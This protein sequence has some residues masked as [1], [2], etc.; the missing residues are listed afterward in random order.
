MDI[1]EIAKKKVLDKTKENLVFPM[2]EQQLTQEQKQ[3]IVSHAK[4]IGC[5]YRDVLDLVLSNEVGY[6]S[7]VA[8]NTSRQDYYEDALVNYI[9]SLNIVANVRKLPKSGFG[10]LYIQRGIL[11]KNVKIE[12]APKDVKSLDLEIT[13]NSGEIVYATHKYTE[14]D[15]GAQNNQHKDVEN[16]LRHNIKSDGTFGENKLVAICDGLYYNKPRGKKGLSPKKIDLVKQVAKE[17]GTYVCDYTTFADFI[18]EIE[19]T[20]EQ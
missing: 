4:R 14:D 1:Y 10:S 20:S 19:E 13:L 6:L 9:D 18:K 15:G 3:K 2:Q 8:K 5:S 16:T 7:I 12:D 11:V 17:T